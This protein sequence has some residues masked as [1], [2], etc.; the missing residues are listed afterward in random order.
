[1]GDPLDLGKRHHRSL[2]ADEKIHDGAGKD[3]FAADVGVDFPQLSPGGVPDVDEKDHNRDHHGHGV[4]DGDH[5]EPGRYRHLEQMVGADVGVDHEQGPEPQQGQGMAVQRRLAGPGDHVIRHRR[6]TGGSAA[7][8]RYCVR[9]TTGERHREF[10]P[11]APVWGCQMTLP[12]PI[13]DGGKDAGAHIPDRHVQDRFFRG[14]TVM[15]KLKNTSRKRRPRPC[16]RAR[17]VRHIP[18]L[19]V[20]RRQGDDVATRATFHRITV[21]MPSFRCTARVRSSRGR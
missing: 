21:A 10:P 12:R 17:S 9:K 4:H 5:L 3:E 15:I 19:G 14:A 8:R 11:G 7:D 20:A 18:G 2:D 13:G 16:P 1:M 6:R